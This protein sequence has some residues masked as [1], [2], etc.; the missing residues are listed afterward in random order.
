MT[1]LFL[2]FLQVQVQVQKM[3]KQPNTEANDKLIEIDKL[4]NVNHSN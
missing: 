2:L 3:R 4:R 1:S